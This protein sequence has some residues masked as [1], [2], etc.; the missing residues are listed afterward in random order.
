M[1][2]VTG[3]RCGQQMENTSLSNHRMVK[4][5]GSRQL[6]ELS[7][8]KGYFHT[9]VHCRETVAAWRVPSVDVG[10]L[11]SGVY[12][13]PARVAGVIRRQKFSLLQGRMMECN[14]PPT[15]SRLL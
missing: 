1:M 15:S 8:A 5:I 13:Y 10:R 4:Y 11:R 9:A 3:T 6:A 12:N 7:S 2:R 14:C